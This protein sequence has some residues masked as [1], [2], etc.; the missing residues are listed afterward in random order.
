MERLTV[1]SEWLVELSD[2]QQEVV[3]G[4][5]G[6][7]VD[8]LIKTGFKELTEKFAFSADVVSSKQGSAVKQIVAAEKMMT[9]TDALKDFSI[10]F[11]GNGGIKIG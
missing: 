6:V 4:G 11:G 2:E 10:D 3:S 9:I 1:Q 7:M 8:D 5:Q